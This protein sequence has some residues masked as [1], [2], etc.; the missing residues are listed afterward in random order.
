MEDGGGGQEEDQHS[1]KINLSEFNTCGV[2]CIILV[3]I[4]GV[5]VFKPTHLAP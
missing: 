1:S 5:Y 2:Q 3:P 4:E